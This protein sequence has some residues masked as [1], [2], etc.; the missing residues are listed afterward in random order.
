MN[1][2]LIEVGANVANNI[3]ENRRVKREAKEARKTQKNAANL[4]LRNKIVDIALDDEENRKAIAETAREGGKLAIKALKIGGILILTGIAGFFVYKGVKKIS[5]KIQDKKEIKDIVADTDFKDR[6]L[7][8]SDISTMIEALKEAMSFDNSWWQFYSASK[9][10]AILKNLQTADDWEY[11]KLKF[12]KIPAAWNDNTPKNL[13]WYLN[14]D[15]KGDVADYSKIITEKTGIQNP[16]GVSLGRIPFL[17]RK[18]KKNTGEIKS[19]ASNNNDNDDSV[20]T[21]AAISRVVKSNGKSK[22]MARLVEA[23]KNR[24]KLKEQTNV[25]PNTIAQ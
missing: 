11:L 24:K 14:R 13:L 6:K 10:S 20:S 9:I 17:K 18:R 22:R 2:A 19:V 5:E 8:D 4:E 12:G 23:L 16:L 3:A 1:P 15:D 7:S 25:D 21:G